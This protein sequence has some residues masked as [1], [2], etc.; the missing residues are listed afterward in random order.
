MATQLIQVPRHL[1]DALTVSSLQEKWVPGDEHCPRIA[2]EAMSVGETRRNV[3]VT[4][5]DRA[6]TWDDWPLHGQSVFVLL[7]TTDPEL[8]RAFQPKRSAASV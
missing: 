7:L 6:L 3:A 1:I 4:V 2:F 5:P 8:D